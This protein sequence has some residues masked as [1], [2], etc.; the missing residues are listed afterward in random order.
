LRRRSHATAER[1]VRECADKQ[2]R[3]SLRRIVVDEVSYGRGHRKYLTIV[4]DHDRGHVVWIGKGK[5]RDTLDPFFAKLGQ[6]RSRRLVC[7][8]M[9]MAEAYVGAVQTHAPQ[10]DI[11]FDRFHIER[12]LTEAVNEVRK[13]EFW[14][15]G[16]RYAM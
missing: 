1:W 10:A 7:V 6:R 4:W 13:V 15:R 16:G 12:H 5:E 3:R 11:V 9:D 8:T 2:F 14:R